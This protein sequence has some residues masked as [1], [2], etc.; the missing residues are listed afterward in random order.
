MLILDYTTLE[1]NNRKGYDQNLKTHIHDTDEAQ[2]ILY[3]EN[4]SDVLNNKLY[5]MSYLYIKQCYTLFT[6]NGISYTI[7]LLY[8]LLKP[9]TFYMLGLFKYSGFKIIMHTIK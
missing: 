3:A 6:R 2:C 8:L 1:L 9:H 5:N 7:V 4:T